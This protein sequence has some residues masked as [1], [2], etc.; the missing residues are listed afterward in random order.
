MAR[1]GAAI[2]YE[3][4]PAYMAEGRPLARRLRQLF[5]LRGIERVLD[6]GANR[7]QYRDFL[8]FDLG[9]QGPILSFEPDPEL[10]EG[11]RARAA[12]LGD[13]GWT[14][15]QLALGREAGRAVMNRMSLNVYNSFRAPRADDP[16]ADPNNT[17]VARFDVEVARLDDLLDELGDLS[18][19]FAKLDTQGFDLEVL[20]GGPRA[21]AQIPLVQSEVSFHAIYEDNPGWAESL[22]AFEA[23]GYRFADLFTLGDSLRDGLPVEA[24]CLFMRPR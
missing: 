11:L 4:Y 6:I 18:R 15:R 3:M 8:R 2:G 22:A 24:D 9:Y 21:F 5:A 16:S 7:G 13:T 10:A 20:A 17:V 12:Q 19:C 23:A 14:V 1:L